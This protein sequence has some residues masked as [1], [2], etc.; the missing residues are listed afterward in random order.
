MATLIPIRRGD[1]KALIIN[2][3]DSTGTAI[4][5]TGYTFFFTVKADNTDAD[6][7]ALISVTQTSLTDPTNGTTTISLSSTD[8]DIAIGLHFYDIQMKDGSGNITT[9][10]SGIFEI[11]QDTTVRTS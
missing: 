7:S 6:V 11:K 8:T 3:L 5:I 4:D 1:S 10:V 9:L 2:V